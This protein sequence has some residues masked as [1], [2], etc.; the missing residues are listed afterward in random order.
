MERRPIDPKSFKKPKGYTNGVL[1][2]GGR[3]LFLAGQVAFDE[4]GVV[5]CPGDLAGQFRQVL[6]NLKAVLAEAG[7]LPEHVTKLTIFVVSKDAYA[8]EMQAIGA[9]WREI[10]GRH[11]PAMTLV[12]V[13][14]LLEPDA[15]VEIEGFAVLP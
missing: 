4:C 14:S 10:F 11:F 12:E 15:L 7:G 6:V 3:L 1:T 13:K 2:E 8:R 9:V 5:V